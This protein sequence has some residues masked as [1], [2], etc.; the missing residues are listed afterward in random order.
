MR[1]LAATL[2]ARNDDALV[3]LRSAASAVSPVQ[4]IVDRV[5]RPVRW[6]VPARVTIGDGAVDSAQHPAVIA[7]CPAV[8]VCEQAVPQQPRGPEDRY[9]ATIGEQPAHG[10]FSPPHPVAVHRRLGASHMTRVDS[11]MPT[12]QATRSSVCH[13]LVAVAS[14]LV[15]P[16]EIAA[17][18]GGLS[19]QRVYQLTRTSDFPEP[20]AKLSTGKVW[21][22]ADVARW[23]RRHNRTVQPLP[24]ID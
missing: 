3:E 2:P 17:M 7:A 1:L 10:A 4:L 16:A 18:L 9:L 13:R 19:R 8:I 24:D 14:A 23:A 6:F 21:A 5:L 11:W 22:Y 20:V 12:S 15:G